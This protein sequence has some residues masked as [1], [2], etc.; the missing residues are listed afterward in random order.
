[1]ATKAKTPKAKLAKVRPPKAERLAA[2]GVTALEPG[3][4][5]I[6]VKI[7]L[8]KEMVARLKAMTAEERGQVL[9]AYMID[10]PISRTSN[11]KGG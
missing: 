6:A 10:H 5:S 1:M 8:P 11:T 4:V 9:V 3:E 2:L 7:R